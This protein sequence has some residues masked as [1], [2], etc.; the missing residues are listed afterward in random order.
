M[1]KFPLGLKPP[2]VLHPSI[3]SNIVLNHL[4]PSFFA[5]GVLL[6]HFSPSFLQSIFEV[7]QHWHCRTV[8][9]SRF[10]C[11]HPCPSC[12][13]ERHFAMGISSR[14]LCMATTRSPRRVLTCCSVKPFKICHGTERHWT[15]KCAATATMK[16]RSTKLEECRIPAFPFHSMPRLLVCNTHRCFVHSSKPF[17]HKFH[18]FHEMLSRWHGTSHDETWLCYKGDVVLLKGRRALIQTKSRWRAFLFWTGPY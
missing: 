7:I 8:F 13:N 12:W 15:C 17:M 16:K 14:I 1:H 9:C 10:V 3:L 4:S 18:H 11:S 5:F 6:K 2:L